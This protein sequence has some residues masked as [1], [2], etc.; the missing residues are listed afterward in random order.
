MKFVTSE[1]I[2]ALF[3]EQINLHIRY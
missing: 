2:M 1:V 3:L